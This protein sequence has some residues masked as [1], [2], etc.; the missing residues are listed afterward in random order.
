[1]NTDKTYAERIASEYA[2][3]QASKVVALKK[4][5]NK[6]K[7]GANIFGYTFGLI[8][9]LVLGVGMCLSMK[10]I[11]DGSTLWFALGIVIGIIGIGGVS[12]N[13]PIYKKLLE[14]G[15]KK[16]GND[17]IELAKQITEEE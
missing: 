3:K 17:I 5:D 8:M 6:A 16:Y 2:P 15:K 14:K 10:V 9:A 11:G 1:M 7:L 12:V 13:Y 4:L